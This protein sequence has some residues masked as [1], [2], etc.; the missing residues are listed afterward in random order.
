MARSFICHS[1]LPASSCRAWAMRGRE[2][3]EKLISLQLDG[4]REEGTA[5]LLI[6]RWVDI[7][8]R[9]NAWK[10]WKKA[11]LKSC[12]S[13]RI[14][15]KFEVR[16]HWIPRSDSD[17]TYSS[18]AIRSS[19]SWPVSKRRRRC[20]PRLSSP[21]SG[22]GCGLGF[23]DK[24]WKA[25]LL[26]SNALG[27]RWMLKQLSKLTIVSLAALHASPNSKTVLF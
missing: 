6:S 26:F 1:R 17:R 13:L 21:V 27:A 9:R 23:L 19:S 5:V 25:L 10:G 8:E 18:S 20:R 7:S 16:I 2:A 12:S 24:I 15:W 22:F 3:N 14:V 11:D 4:S